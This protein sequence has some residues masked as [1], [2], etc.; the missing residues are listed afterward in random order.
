MRNLDKVTLSESQSQEKTQ[1]HRELPISETPASQANLNTDSKV[2]LKSLFQNKNKIQFSFENTQSNPNIDKLCTVARSLDSFIDDL[3]EGEESYNNPISQITVSPT[4]ALQQEFESRNLPPIPFIKFDGNPSRWPEFIENFFARAHSKRTFDGNTRMTGLLS[5]LDGEAK[6]TLEAI[7]CNKTFY[8][9][10]L[11]TLKRDFGNTLIVAHSTLCSVFNKAQIEANDKVGLRQ[12]HQQLKCNNSWLL[13]MGYKSP[14]FSNENL[15]KA[16]LRLPSHLRN[17]FYKFTKDS[18]LM[19]GSINLLVFETG[20]DDQ[21]KVSFNPLADIVNKQDLASKGR[22]SLHK[23]T[24]GS[25]NVLETSQE[26][27][28][29]SVLESKG[30]INTI[31][32]KTS[33]KEE[34][35]TQGLKCWL[36]RENHRLKDCQEFLIKSVKDRKRYIKE[37]N[38]VGTVYPIDI[39]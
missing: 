18:N 34:K 37:Q 35:K 10:A 23:L 21:I 20:L 7:G 27:S 17:Q 12:F 28:D 24:N 4:L 26:V 29:S 32:E 1:I 9:T 36:Y 8:A 38:S 3:V 19:D 22:I 39:E 5:V 15:T 31:V 30:N 2:G 25:N 14:I 16:I 6:L 11:K 13:S 33:E